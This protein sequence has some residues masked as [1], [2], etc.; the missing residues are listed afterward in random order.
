M[1]LYPAQAEVHLPGVTRV[2]DLSHRQKT[3]K[4]TGLEPLIHKNCRAETSGLAR[5][6]SATP[7]VWL[8]KISALAR[9]SHVGVQPARSADEINHGGLPTPV[10]GSLDSRTGGRLPARVGKGSSQATEIRQAP[11]GVLARR[12]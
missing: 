11:R 3:G 5:A 8:A 12:W 9:V 10:E 1:S 7:P 6:G 2:I 4:L